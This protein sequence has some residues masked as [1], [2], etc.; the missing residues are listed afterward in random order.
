MIAPGWVTE[1]TTALDPLIAPVGGVDEPVVASVSRVYLKHRFRR[2]LGIGLRD[3]SALAVTDHEVLVLARRGR[4][5]TV[6]GRYPRDAA[7]VVEFRTLPPGGELLTDRLVIHV[8]GVAIRADF[9]GRLHRDAEGV[10][11]ALGG[12]APAR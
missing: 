12:I 1:R 2:E 11:A 8:G 10:V 9:D 6:A 3:Q 7:R 5:T 4:R